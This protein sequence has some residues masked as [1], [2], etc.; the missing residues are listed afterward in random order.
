MLRKHIRL[1]IGSA[2]S[3][4]SARTGWCQGRGMNPA[5]FWCGGFTL[6]EMLVVMTIIM[7][8]MAASSVLFRMPGSR[9][10]EPAARMSRCIDLARAQAVA[11]NRSVAI[12][13]DKQEVG[14]RELVMRFLENRPG[15][16]GATTKEFRRPERFEDI[17]IAKDLVIEPRSGQTEVPAAEK[18]ETH[19]LAAGESLVIN[20]DGQVLLGT[21]E[22]G[23]PEVADQLVPLIQLGVQP[24]RGGK[25][26]AA[27]KKDIAIVQVQCASGS[28]R[29]IQP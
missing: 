5:S 23:F 10:N 28:S 22:S 14:S 3:S 15:K 20:S 6:V 19:P 9:A 21:G 11:N 26:V 27:A 4:E 16:N 2:N 12:R 29:V 25:V 17:V 7:L 18:Q 1:D 8:L 24:T 13:F